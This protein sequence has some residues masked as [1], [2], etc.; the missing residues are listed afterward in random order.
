VIAKLREASAW[1]EPRPPDHGRGVVL[2]V[3]QL[4][5]GV[6]PIRVRLTLLADGS[7]EVLTGLPE[8]GTGA[9]TVMQRVVATELGIPP[10]RVR[11]RQGGTLEAD[12]DPGHGG[13]RSTVFHGGAA[14]DGAR[15]LKAALGQD[16]A[17]SLAAAARRIGPLTVTG[18]ASPSARDDGAWGQVVEVSV[19]RETGAFRLEDV[20]IVADVGTV[21][22]PLALHGTLEGGFVMGLG[23]AIME[24]VHIEEG[25]V[26][27][28]S[29]G[30]YKLPTIGD[31]PPIRVLL[32]TADPG[33]GPYGAKAGGE[34]ANPGPGAAVANAIADAVGVRIMSLPITAEKIVA[35]LRRPRLAE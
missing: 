8:Q 6:Y 35:A 18:V 24:E 22:S 25:R 23:Q 11:V 30:E 2:G 5:P 19:D 15:K 20:V 26:T 21:I 1:D 14:L 9:Y 13:S 4:R 17:G 10:D 32:H 33:P 16:G 29:L 28:S 34:L 12:E 27:T 3:H 31:I 7:V